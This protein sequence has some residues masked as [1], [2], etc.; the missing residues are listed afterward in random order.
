MIEF[1]DNIYV[2]LSLLSIV[3]TAVIWVLIQF[4][5]LITLGGNHGRT[6]RGMSV[7]RQDK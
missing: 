5:K 6:M 1:I 3:A 4:K 2:F 7:H